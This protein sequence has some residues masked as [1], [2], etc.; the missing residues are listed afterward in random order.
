MKPTSLEDLKDKMLALL[1]ATRYEIKAVCEGPDLAAK[2]WSTKVFS[3]RQ[4]YRR[5]WYR[6]TYANF[7]ISVKTGWLDRIKDVKDDKIGE[8][9]LIDCEP[10]GFSGGY[11][12]FTLQYVKK[13]VGFSI[14]LVPI[15]AVKIGVEI[16]PQKQL[17]K[18]M[19]V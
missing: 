3:S 7:R 1:N 13:S 4:P 11:E 10:Q 9:V 17:P 16:V 19:F 15:K 6:D 12:R 18:H 8:V 2:A 14:K 5:R